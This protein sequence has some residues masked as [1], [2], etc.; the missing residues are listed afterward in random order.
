MRTPDRD[1]PTR[2]MFAALALTVGLGSAVLAACGSSDA[3][4]AGTVPAV[5]ATTRPAS[6]T[7]ATSAPQTT[8]A[9][10]TTSAVISTAPA[11]T[12]S[13]AP[14][15]T[16]AAADVISVTDAD[17]ADLEKQLDDVDQLLAGVDADLQQD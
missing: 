6:T 3:G 13:P 17:I 11:A 10:P 2:G 7:P 16:E 5:V 1:H 14:T 4:G 12:D 9:P 15:T 8:D